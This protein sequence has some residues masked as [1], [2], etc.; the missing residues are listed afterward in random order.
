MDAPRTLLSWSSG[1]DG[2]YALSVMRERRIADVVGLVTII[3]ETAH[4][5]PLHFVP[6]R[7]LDCQAQALGLPLWKIEIPWP[8]PDATYQAAMHAVA[9]RAREEGITHLAF[10]DLYLADIRAYRENV[11]RSTGLEPMFPLWD[12]DTS[13]LAVTILAAG[14]EATVT[15]IDQ[16]QVEIERAGA[17]YDEVFLGSLP[18]DVDPCGENGEFHTFVSNGPGFDVPITT[19]VADT[20][21]DGVFVFADI[22]PVPGP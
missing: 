12:W 17:R 19:R 6:E 20:V 13:D 7:L 16:T 8:C 3:D 14:I 11:L 4:R 2:A 5:V 22:V 15:C 1:K 9:Q 21:V 18:A 10:G